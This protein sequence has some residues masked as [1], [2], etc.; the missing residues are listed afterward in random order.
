MAS[1]R[2]SCNCW[3]TLFFWQSK[4]KK[5]IGEDY[6]EKKRKEKR[7]VSLSTRNT[8]RTVIV[9]EKTQRQAEQDL[10]W[11][12]RL[13]TIHFGRRKKKKK[14]RSGVCTFTKSFHNILLPCFPLYIWEVSRVLQHS[15][16]WKQ[17]ACVSS[18]ALGTHW[19][20]KTPARLSNITQTMQL[21]S[22]ILVCCNIYAIQRCL[23]P[24]PWEMTHCSCWSTK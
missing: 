20:K 14:K 22:K 23:L 18:Q 8:Q 11:T 1:W 12:T 4:I 7:S 16:M 10:E 24:C 5:K 9:F 21:C 2:C 15:S 13:L 6:E 3:W 19:L 17:R